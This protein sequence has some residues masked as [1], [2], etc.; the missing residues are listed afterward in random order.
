[1]KVKILIALNILIILTF[2]TIAQTEY[3]LSDNKVYDFLERMESL[4]I[5]QRYNSLEIPK[6]RNEIAGFLKEVITNK[7]KLDESDNYLLTDLEAEFELE[8]Y[9][10]LTKSQKLIGEGY[11]NLYSQGEKYLY[12]VNDTSANVNLF[13]NSAGKAQAIYANY[14]SPNHIST[15]TIWQEELQI[16]GS[17]FNK[18]GFFYRGGNGYIFGQREAALLRKEL[19]YNY[20]YELFGSY[21]KTT[22]GYI[23][24]DLGLVKAKFGRDRM[25]IG[26]GP[27]KAVLGNN[28]P[29]F[30]NLSLKFHYKSV[31]V[32]YF[33]GKLI[34][35][36][37]FATDSITAGVN[38][39]K[40]KYIGY[41]RIGF[42]ISDD[43]NIGAGEMIIYG[44]RPIDL[45]YLNPF[46]LYKT[47]QNNNKDRDNS[48]VILDFNNK[49]IKGLKI[50][51]LLFMD[52]IEVSKFGSPYWGNQFIY[53]LGFVSNNFYKLLP[54]ELQFEYMRIDPYV[55]T[56]RLPKNTFTNDGYGLAS[57]L[58]PNS[59]LFLTQINYRFNNRL[60]VTATLS[61]YV[62]GAN[63]L[64]PDGSIKRNVGGDILV[65][66][67]TFDDFDAPFL[68]GDK[69]IT[70]AISGKIVYEPIKD[71]FFT[72]LVQYKNVSLQNSVNNKMIE[73]YLTFNYIL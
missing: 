40:E 49:S 1:M 19:N 23:T 67:R 25:N 68:D 33:H 29:I 35:D 27:V 43:F 50:Y 11:F 37:G 34:G 5:I 42:N 21:D 36:S 26:Y 6:S 4:Q 41:H 47:A 48:V 13:F 38:T 31:E 61:Y 70:R 55:Y 24:A 69:E 58:Q 28:A 18:I 53:N 39:I 32:T 54:L 17:F 22:A 52:D 44:D 62:H 72:G 45:N 64:N 51:G 65:G 20:K 57:Y 59:E 60:C 16:R 30:D 7:D 12:F 9:G 71:Y 3:V 10:T 14:S 63:P 73:A 66:H 56:N 15:A 2:N 46:I 8:L